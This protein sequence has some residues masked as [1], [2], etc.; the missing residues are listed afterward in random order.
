MR[1]KCISIINIHY[2]HPNYLSFLL[3]SKQC[4]ILLDEFGEISENDAYHKIFLHIHILMMIILCLSDSG[5]D[6][7]ST[8]K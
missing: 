7:W 4:E 8:R 2:G 6:L 3:E 5:T 1:L